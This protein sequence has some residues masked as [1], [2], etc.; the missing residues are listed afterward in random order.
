MTKTG[1]LGVKVQEEEGKYLN[2]DQNLPKLMSDPN[3]Q[4]KEAQRTSI[5]VNS[6]ILTLKLSE[7]YAVTNQLFYLDINYNR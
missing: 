6:K 3:I 5:R 4:F 7:K 2:S 1:T